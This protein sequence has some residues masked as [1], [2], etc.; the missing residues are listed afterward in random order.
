[1]QANERVGAP[2][3]AP[4]LKDGSILQMAARVPY[5]QLGHLP[6]GAPCLPPPVR[7]ASSRTENHKPHREQLPK[8]A[9]GPGTIHT[10]LRIGCQQRSHRAKVSS[11][12]VLQRHVFRTGAAV[13]HWAQRTSRLALDAAVRAVQIV[14]VDRLPPAALLTTVRVPGVPAG[15]ALELTLLNRATAVQAAILWPDHDSSSSGPATPR[16]VR[17]DISARY[18]G[19]WK[20]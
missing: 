20:L 8:Q 4:T 6:E 13:P 11:P 12:L 16:D 15:G 9:T 18:S 19:A 7:S 17:R 2:A 14:L 10:E 3:I 5:T 1:M